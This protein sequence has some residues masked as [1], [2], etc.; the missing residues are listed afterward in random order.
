MPFVTE[1]IY[2]SVSKWAYIKGNGPITSYMA[3]VG[4]NESIMIDEWPMY[5]EQFDFPAHQQRISEVIDVIR[6]IR[7]MRSEKAV[8]PS[9]KINCFFVTSDRNISEALEEGRIY[10]ERLAALNRFDVK[11]N[12]DGVSASDIA[13]IAGGVEAFFPSGDLIDYEGEKKRLEKELKNLDNEIERASK[14][15]DNAGFIEKAPANVIEEEKK[16]LSAYKEARN[17]VEDNLKRL[18]S[19][20]NQ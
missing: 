5:S 9:R 14:K 1:E 17:K 20:F 7:N 3:S 4:Q 8:P 12:K 19:I 11:D 6:A 10:I 18:D 15:L 16:K 2:S 13:V